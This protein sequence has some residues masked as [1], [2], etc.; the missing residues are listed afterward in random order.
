[1]KKWLVVDIRKRVLV[2]TNNLNQAWDI[3]EGICKYGGN[4]WVVK[5]EKQG[6]KK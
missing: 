3:V 4:L 2:D 1:M 6:D 5:N